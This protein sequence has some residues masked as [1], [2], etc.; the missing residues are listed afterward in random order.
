MRVIRHQAEVIQVS[1][2]SFQHADHP[3]PVRTNKLCLGVCIGPK[4]HDHAFTT[5]QSLQPVN[6]LSQHLNFRRQAGSDLGFRL[7]PFGFF[8]SR[9][10]SNKGTKCDIEIRAARTFAGG[11][12][13]Q[14]MSRLAPPRSPPHSLSGGMIAL[15][16]PDWS[17]R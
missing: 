2:N 14:F 3:R 17:V 1:C 7:R 12:R 9:L 15:N 11:S 8:L 16:H 4:I 5:L 13:L 6:A 10:N